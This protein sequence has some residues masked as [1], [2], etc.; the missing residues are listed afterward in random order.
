MEGVGCWNVGLGEWAQEENSYWLQ[1][2]RSEGAGIRS[3]TIRN[4]CERNL[5]CQRS[6][7]P[8]LSGAQEAGPP[9][10]PLPLSPA[11]V[12]TRRSTHRSRLPLPS[13]QYLLWPCWPQ[14]A[15][16]PCPLLPPPALALEG[17]Q[18]Q[19]LLGGTHAEVGLKPQLSPWGHA[20]NE[21]ELDS[22]VMAARTIDLHHCCWL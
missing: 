16:T 3:S 4:V 10:C 2:D 17:S 5:G 7:M 18:V 19:V 8:L 11:L 9:L 6:K 20:T 13:C 1:T 15:C 22:L 21:D 14:W 12:G